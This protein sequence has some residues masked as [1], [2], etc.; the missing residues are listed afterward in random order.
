MQVPGRRPRCAS[1]DRACL[2]AVA[3]R[4]SGSTATVAAEGQLP[5][6]E[7]EQHGEGAADRNEP[8]QPV[9]EQRRDVRETFVPKVELISGGPIA[10]LPLSYF[11]EWRVVSLELLNNGTRRDRGGRFED[12]FINWEIDDRQ[13]THDHC[14]QGGPRGSRH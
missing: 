12:A 11:I 2:F 4:G 6:G 13:Q 9:S 5:G 8:E 3:Q 14:R 1:C 7:P 10:G